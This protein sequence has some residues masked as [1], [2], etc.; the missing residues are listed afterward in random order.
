MNFKIIVLAAGKGSR[1]K[2]DIP[3]ALTPVGGKPIIQHLHESILDSGV[4]SK[5][6]IVIGHER[7]QI[8]DGFGGECQYVVQEEQLGT[9]H[10]VKMAKDASYSSHAVIVLNGDHP[11]VSSTTLR[12]LSELH[13][14]SG[15]VLTMMTTTVP[16]FTGFYAAYLHWG[17]ILRDIHGH[18]IGVREF[19]DAMDSER[20]IREVNPAFY[21]FDSKW[22]WENIEQVKNINSKEE[23]YLTDL[24]ELAVAQGNEIVSMNVAPEEAMG[25]NT[26]EE[27]SIA[28]NLLKER[29]EK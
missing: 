23:Y 18:I 24:I 4:D 17:R 8:C 1:M 25:I 14:R 22:L 13:E 20:E 11:F 7:K 3:K 28:E 19:K 16:S 21:C 5:P 9:A 12:R 6:I 2:S 27:L 26:P 29:V 15:G 10:A